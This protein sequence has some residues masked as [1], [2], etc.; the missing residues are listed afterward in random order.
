[1]PRPK[2]L[3]PCAALAASAAVSIAAPMDTCTNSPTT[4]DRIECRENQ[5]RA[6]ETKQRQYLDA[7]VKR[8]ALFDLKSQNLTDEQSAW[9]KYRESHC[10][11]VYLLWAQGSIRYEM[12]AT[13]NIQL[14][15][16]RTYD[17]WRSYLTNLDSTPPVL[18]NPNQ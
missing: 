3:L 17:L 6:E 2:T 1:M 9:V 14:A 11:N 5:L 10:G 13:C 8:A 18:P 4:V 16:E 12:A 7:A 15:R